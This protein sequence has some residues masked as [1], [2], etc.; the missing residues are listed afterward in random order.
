MNEAVKTTMRRFVAGTLAIAMVLTALLLVFVRPKA[1]NAASQLPVL[2]ETIVG[3]VKFQSFNFLGKNAS[4]DDGVDYSA[5]F[6]YTDDYFAHSAVNDAA[7]AQ[8]M[9]WTALDDVS[10]AACS[11]DLA[12]ASYA[13]AA[14]DVVS[15]SPRTWDN[16]DYSDRAANARE[17]L[18]ACGFSNFENYDYD[19]APERDGVAYVI[20]SK[21]IHIYDEVTQQNKDFTLIAVGVRGAGYGAEW[22]SN[23]EIGTPGNGASNV[24]HEGFDGSA[25]KVRDGVKT[26]LQEQ[27][28]SGDVKYWVSGFSRAAAVANLTAGYLTDEATDFYTTQDDVYGYT[29]ECPQGAAASENALNYKNIHNIVNAMD[30]VPMVSPSVFEHQRLGVDYVMPYYGNTTSSEN[31]EYYERMYRVLNSIA[32]GT[33]FKDGTYEEDP[34]IAAV[35][36]DNYPYNRPVPIYTLT[37][38]Q[39]IS[40]A[41]SGDLMTNFGTKLATGSDNKLGSVYMDQFLENVLK[42][43]L[44][45]GAW[46]RNT[47]DTCTS[48]TASTYMTHKETYIDQYQAAFQNAFAYFLDFSGPAF[49]DMVDAVMDGIQEQLRISNTLTNG[50]LA[51]AFTNF[52]NYPDNTYRW[53]WQSGFKPWVGSTSWVGKTRKDVLIKEA[54]PVVRNVVH[55]MVSDYEADGGCDTVTLSQ[56][57]AALDLIVEVVIDLYAD[58][59]SQ[60]NSNYFGTT[61]HYLNTILST[62]EQET[63]LSWITSLDDNHMNRSYRT[64]T[65]PVGTNVKLYEFREQYGETLSKDG[66]APLVAE[67]TNGTQVSSL[68]Q[69]IYMESDGTTMTIRYPASLNIRS[70]VTLAPGSTSVS[71]LDYRV[72]DFQTKLD[73][74]DVSVG[75][76]QF[77]TLSNNT[78]YKDITNTSRTNAA[79]INSASA[80]EA[81]ALGPYDTL[82]IMANGST[83]FDNHNAGDENVYTVEV[84]RYHVVTFEETLED[85]EGTADANFTLNLTL[86]P[87]AGASMP[88]DGL[89]VFY[90]DTTLHFG[91]NATLENLPADGSVSFLVLPEGWTLTLSQ[92][93]SNGYLTQKYTIT[94]TGGTASIVEGETA[95]LVVSGD[96]AVTI[97]NLYYLPPPTG[98]LEDTG[99]SVPLLIAIVLIMCGGA[100]IAYVYRKK[101]EFVG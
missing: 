7:T 96:M 23:V 58:E 75:A 57:D 40:D 42:V 44:R 46:N 43:C 69:R 20:A 26:Y 2:N 89:D 41:I 61:L 16:T 72:A 60:Y 19:H 38:G 64:L 15:A 53:A 33:T 85:L 56:L 47:S 30:V 90:N 95:S 92:P 1:E 24:R 70:D 31:T 18:T 62:H 29:W 98:I 28:I 10:L 76:T 34:L 77:Q 73:T 84:E 6:Y 8:K 50:G 74:T 36:P 54:Q 79:D 71:D 67:F 97:Q 14:G 27:G 13:T 88:E 25:R 9:P 49:M 12:V 5:T 66:V 81:V 51:L 3:T 93:S 86:T 63:V 82:K 22:A 35:D 52:Y 65:V 39:L 87:P 21:Q 48:D 94:P 99:E 55:N 80:T 11:M 45:S 37:A 17:F 91:P 4:G 100:G 68:D 101:D 32:V 83:S 78:R 59:L